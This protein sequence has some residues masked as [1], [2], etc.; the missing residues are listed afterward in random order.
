M[1]VLR[2]EVSGTNAPYHL[3][4]GRSAIVAS[5]AFV[6]PVASVQGRHT[7]SCGPSYAPHTRP[8]SGL[9]GFC[10]CGAT[11]PSHT[12]CAARA[13]AAPSA[14]EEDEEGE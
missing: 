3:V 11:G 1:T 10:W 12:G 2:I 5:A 7:W 13:R 6:A 14:E 9:V 4:R 8:A